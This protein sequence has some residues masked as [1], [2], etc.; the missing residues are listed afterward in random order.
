M[1]T[2]RAA[3]SRRDTGKLDSARSGFASNRALMSG[4][5]TQMEGG[6]LQVRNRR[7]F[8]S[9]VMS[10][11]VIMVQALVEDEVAKHRRIRVGDLM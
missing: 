6:A 9:T 5:D 7:S 8:A 4:R 10:S 3:K 1:I 2:P 11:R